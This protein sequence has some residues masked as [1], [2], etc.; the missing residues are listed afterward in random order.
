MMHVA[1]SNVG[2]ICAVSAL[3]G[4]VIALFATLVI[5]V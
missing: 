5:A 3:W 4:I 1:R 2:G